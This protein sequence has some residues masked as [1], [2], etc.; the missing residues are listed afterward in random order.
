ML[1]DAIGSLLDQTRPPDEIIVV[2]DASVDDTR[3]VARSYGEPVIVVESDGSGP[4]AARN[5]GI[6]AATGEFIGFLDSDDLWPRSALATQLALLDA[7]PRAAIAWSKGMWQVL[8]GGTPLGDKGDGA[9][10]RMVGVNSMLFRRSALVALRGFDASMRFGED[11]DIVR[12]SRAAG[13][14]VVEGED[15]V[16]IYRRHPGNMTADRA[17]ARKGLLASAIAALRSRAQ[18]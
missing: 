1:P 9:V 15:V 14:R 10:E 5:V 13:L 3:T 17:A 16:A 18:P 8:A 4:A 6:A 12:R 2:D 7:H 11:H